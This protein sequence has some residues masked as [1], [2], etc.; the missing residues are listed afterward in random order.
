MDLAVWLCHLLH[1]PSSNTTWPGLEILAEETGYSVDWVGRSRARLC[2]NGWLE[3]IPERGERGRFSAPRF[4]VL[5]PTVRRKPTDGTARR[6]V[7]NSVP[8]KPTRGGPLYYSF[9]EVE[10]EKR[11]R[12]PA[13]WNPTATSQETPKA[14]GLGKDQDPARCEPRAVSE[15]KSHDDC[16]AKQ[17]QLA[18]AIWRR[19]LEVLEPRVGRQNFPTWFAPTHGAC[20]HSQTLIV[21]VPT[22]CH[23]RW[24]AGAGAQQVETALRERGPELRVEY[25][26]WQQAGLPRQAREL[27]DQ[28]ALRQVAW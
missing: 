2:R 1:S 9:D 15:L 4:R 26:V 14:F 13:A 19:V 25:I 10:Q 28:E 5:I 27:S 17:R 21:E 23:A 7:T 18:Q 8:E 20:V 3:Q 6:K 24:L 11:S 22:D 16:T 12:A